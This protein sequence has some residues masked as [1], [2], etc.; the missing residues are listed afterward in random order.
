MAG[1]PLP[2][3]TDDGSASVPSVLEAADHGADPSVWSTLIS[4]RRLPFDQEVR[5]SCANEFP[6]IRNIHLGRRTEFHYII[7]WIIR[8]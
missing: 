5:W 4:L 8:S 1:I 2:A 7:A 3:D 6:M